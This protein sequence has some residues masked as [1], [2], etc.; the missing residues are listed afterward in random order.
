MEISKFVFAVISF[1]Y[2]WESERKKLYFNATWTCFSTKFPIFRFPATNSYFREKTQSKLIC[3]NW[4]FLFI[5]YPTHESDQRK[6]IILSGYCISFLVKCF[7]FD[8]IIR[9][10]CLGKSMKA[11]YAPSMCVY[12]CIRYYSIK[13]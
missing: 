4:S 1:D 10:I 3:C 2:D 5:K 11:T 6:D 9:Q 13:S 8:I 12:D 7:Q